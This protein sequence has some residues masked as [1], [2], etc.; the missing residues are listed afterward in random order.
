MI[1]TRSTNTTVA[2]PNVFIL[3]HCV[4][5]GGAGGWRRGSFSTSSADGANEML[6]IS[7][8]QFFQHLTPMLVFF[9]LCCI[10]HINGHEYNQACRN[11][12]TDMPGAS[13]SSSSLLPP[14]FSPPH[15]KKCSTLLFPA[16]ASAIH[17][18][19]VEASPSRVYGKLD[20][21]GFGGQVCGK[22]Q[23]DQGRRVELT[24][25]YIIVPPSASSAYL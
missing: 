10:N 25:C 13:S 14:P 20:R 16:G 11:T 7:S 17:V 4:C 23:R 24:Q 18:L 8:V 2:V 12:R 22:V 3:S 9:F 19:I 6:L 15:A 21:S 5:R 1:K